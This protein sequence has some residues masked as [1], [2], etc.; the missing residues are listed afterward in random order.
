MKFRD[1]YQTFLDTFHRE[2]INESAKEIPIGFLKA[3]KFLEKAVKINSMIL[4]I[5]CGNGAFL[6]LIK[7]R[8]NVFGAD[9]SKEYAKY[10]KKHG[11]NV[12]VCNV[13]NELPFS[14]NS[15]DIIT[16]FATLEH[17][18]M[19]QYNLAEIN[20]IMKKN[21]YLIISI[22]NG[23]YIINWFIMSFMPQYAGLSP[24]FGS[25]DHCN[26]FT[27]YDIKLI[28]N[29]LNFKIEKV[30]GFPIGLPYINFI[31]KR[32]PLYKLSNIFSSNFNIYAKK[33]GNCKSKE[34]LIKN[35]NMKGKWRL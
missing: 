11:I 22:P 34:Q 14:S 1:D 10:C 31:T 33:I 21:G 28:L 16:M 19:P 4:D 30:E 9:I 12:R 7:T 13:E 6:N 20:R 18:R 3:K 25:Y 5:G 24:S 32:I 26:H 23:G 8:Y 15:F 35:P 17:I 29:N 27:L 2:H